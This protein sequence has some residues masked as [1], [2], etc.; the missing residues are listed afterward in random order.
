MGTIAWN[1]TQFHVIRVPLSECKLN[2][3][4]YQRQKEI[5]GPLLE[6]DMN[7]PVHQVEKENKSSMPATHARTPTHMAV[8]WDIQR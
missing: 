7:K 8:L 1:P 4:Y 6:G 3:S 5:R 2:S